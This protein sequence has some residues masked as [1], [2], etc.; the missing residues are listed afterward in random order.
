RTERED[1]RGAN[2][3]QNTHVV[4]P[5]PPSRNT[6]RPLASDVQS[7]HAPVAPTC[8]VRKG[9]TSRLLTRVGFLD[10]EPGATLGRTASASA[11]L[12]GKLAF[13]IERT[14]VSGREQR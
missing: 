9:D 7:A 4:L 11:S 13:A 2:E 5:L 10:C 3:C 12:P 8:A 1:H 14:A 6:R